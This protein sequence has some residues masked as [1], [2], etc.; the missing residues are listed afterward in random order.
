MDPTLVSPFKNCYPCRPSFIPGGICRDC[1]PGFF[2]RSSSDIHQVY[3][4]SSGPAEAPGHPN[5]QLPRQLAYFSQLQGAGDSS[6]GLS[7]SPT[8][9]AWPPAE[10][11]EER[12]HPSP[13]DHILGSLPGLNLDA[14]PTGPCSG[15]EHSVVYGPLQARLARVSVPVSQGP[16]PHGGSSPSSSLGTAPYE[17]IPLVDEVPGYSS[18]L[19]FPSPSKS[20]RRLF[21]HPFSV[22]GPQFSLERSTHWGNLPSPNDND[23]CFPLGMGSGFRGMTGLRCLVRQVPHLAH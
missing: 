14:G 21:L 23:G 22:A 9:R 13:A 19:A 12:A 5:P 15:R 20:V 7:P 10:W 11:P 2:V 3:G 8:S 16:R 4:C 18:L 6:Q 1:R 17:T